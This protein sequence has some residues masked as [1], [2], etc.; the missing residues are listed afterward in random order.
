M[1]TVPFQLLKK[2]GNKCAQIMINYCNPKIVV[3]VRRW[4][5]K[6]KQFIEINCPAVLVLCSKSKGNVDLSD[7]GWYF[8]NK[9]PIKAKGWYLK[10]LFHCVNIGKMN[11]WP[12]FCRY[13]HQLNTPKN[14]KI[15]LMKFTLVIVATFNK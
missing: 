12:T 9:M 10:V 15:R 2:T 14:S 7:I 11:V 6:K 5:L 8:F 4:G 1:L 3:R 13:C